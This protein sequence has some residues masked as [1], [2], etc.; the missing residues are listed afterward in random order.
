MTSMSKSKAAVKAGVIG[1]PID[2]SLSPRLH[3]YWLNAY[4][5]DGLYEK[6][7]V[8]L[9][10]LAH[11]LANLAANGYCGVNLTVPHKEAAIK[12]VDEMD[13]VARRV[14]AVNTITVRDGK[15]FG[16]NTDVFGFGENLRSAGF[17][18]QDK[19]ITL[20]GAGGAARAAVVAMLDM[21]APEIRVVN[22]NT[23]RAAGLRDDFGDKIKVFE[24]S[25]AAALHD[26]QLLINA[27]SLGMKGQLSLKLD[28]AS[29]PTDAWVTDM[30]YSPLVTDLLQRAAARGNKT[31]DGLGMLLHQA[32]P[33]FRAFFGHDPEVTPAL[34]QHVLEGSNP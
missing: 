25:D 28:L 27:T 5:I 6:I 12:T 22:R 34:R 20:I 16:S 31:V 29:L 17:A 32:R 15:L 24:W 14:G 10:E 18:M 33:A 13:D 26:A 3:S 8:P 9:P 7:A 30:V 2:H 11:T 19:P 21:G 4:G 1:W 23:E